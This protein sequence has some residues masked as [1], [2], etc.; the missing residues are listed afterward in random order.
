LRPAFKL[1]N[2][3][4]AQKVSFRTANTAFIHAPPLTAARFKTS[5]ND[6]PRLRK[7][8]GYKLKAIEILRILKTPIDI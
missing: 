3:Y 4:K 8:Y 5:N 1:F 7:L 2:V 6:K